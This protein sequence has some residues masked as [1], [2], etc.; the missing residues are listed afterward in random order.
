[1]HDASSEVGSTGAL[2]RLG[3][4]LGDHAGFG[5]DGGDVVIEPR[6][7]GLAD[8]VQ[9][10]EFFGV[11]HHRHRGQG[12]RPAG[13]AGAA[14]ARDDGQPQLD[15]GRYQ[16]RHL[17]LAVG[18]QHQ[19]GVL[20]APVGGVGDVGD[21]RHA[22]ET[23]VV[24]VGVPRQQ[25]RCAPAQAIGVGEFALEGADR[26]DRQAHQSLDAF[27]ANARDGVVVAVQ[28]AGAPPVD[29]AQ[30][31]V[32][33][34]D[35]QPTPLRVVDQV[36]L[37]VGIAPHHPDVAQHL[38]EH[39]RRAAGA[40]LATQL[41]QQPPGV[42]AQQARDDLAV[43]ERGVVVRNFAQAGRTLGIGMQGGQRQRR[44]HRDFA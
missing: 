23:D 7:A 8:R 39:A 31:M 29:L 9:A 1:M 41:A 21:A 24:G 12:H 32:Q 14:A 36:I 34:L 35:Q 37:E 44:V 3:D 38:E 20:D 16:R 6:Q 5:E 18:H 25:P 4:A 42:L 43:A 30:P 26:L 27:G 2:G 33:G 15:A 40:A 13:V 19:E 11:D 10:L 28:V 17:G 22:V